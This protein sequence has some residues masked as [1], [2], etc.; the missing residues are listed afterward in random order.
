VLLVYLV[1]VF[2]GFIGLMISLLSIGGREEGAEAADTVQPYHEEREEIPSG[3]SNVW[4]KTKAA[5]KSKAKKARK[6]AKRK[7]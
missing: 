3:T 5:K 7:K 6:S 1:G 2:F 4:P